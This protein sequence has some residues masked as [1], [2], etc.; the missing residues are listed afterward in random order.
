MNSATF[1]PQDSAIEA[2]TDKVLGTVHPDLAVRWRRAA[3]DMWE[4][5]RRRMRPTEGLRS[6]ARQWEVYSQGR[7]K[8]KDGTWIVV[9]KSKVI[10]K[11]K[12]ITSL[13]TYGLA[14]DSCFV[15]ND[16]YLKYFD[17]KERDFLWGEF[18]RFIQAHG[19]QWSGDFNGNGK[20][21]PEDFE[22]VHCQLKYGMDLKKIQAL[23]EFDGVKAVWAKVDQI[24]ACGG[25]LV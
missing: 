17:K 20:E 13:H 16:P 19:M 21:D 1:I 10:S 9:D 14:L 5:H 15:S 23:Y 7:K 4:S 25:A 8:L 11:S 18:G 12:P 24:I 6:I 3:Q 2:N 22:K